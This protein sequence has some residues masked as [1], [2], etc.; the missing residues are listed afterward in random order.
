MTFRGWPAEALEFY[1]GLEADNSRT[2]WSAH[3]AFYEEAVYGPMAALLAE[4]EDEFGPGKIFRPNRDLRFSADKSPYKTHIGAVLERGGYVQLSA[5]GLAAGLGM[6][7]LA[8]DQLDRYRSAVAEDVTG[9][10]LERVLAGLAKKRIEVV[11]LN[12]LKTAP[13][14]YPKDHPRIELLRHKG[15]IAWQE[16]PVEP[17]LGTAEAKKK[18]VAFLR[19]A[20]PLHD[21]LGTRVGPSQ[22]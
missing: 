17:W 5:N 12:S 19:G 18:I 1:E 10:E 3:K 21:W 8:A 16:W 2:Y 9:R 14:G 13:R 6:Y 11:G 22:L 4:L 15:L 7:H 20:R